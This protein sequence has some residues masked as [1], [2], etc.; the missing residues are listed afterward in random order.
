MAFFKHFPKVDYNGHMATNLM[1]RT[2]INKSVLIDASGVIEYTIQD[3]DRADIVSQLA[4]QDSQQDWAVYYANDVV[5]PYHDWYLNTNDFAEYVTAKYGSISQSIA[6]TVEYSVTSPDGEERN[7]DH[8]GLAVNAET[9][10]E[11]ILDPEKLQLYVYTRVSAYDME[12]EDN[13]SKLK[14]KLLNEAYIHE[15]EQQLI[16]RLKE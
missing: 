6:N 3:S 12:E 13:L 10:A 5:D 14:I 8:Y 9:Y 11:D 4:Y 1:A 16:T 15:A 2:K 7:I